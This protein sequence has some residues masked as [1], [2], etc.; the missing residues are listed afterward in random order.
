M[1]PYD[2]LTSA[3]PGFKSYGRGRGMARC[4]AHKDRTRSLS[5]REFD[6]G[7]VG[8]HCFAG[9]EVDAIV[10]AVGLRLEDL[11][12]ERD[13][14]PGA[15]RTADRR[16]YTARQVLDALRLELGVAWVL[17]ADI[18]AGR[19]IDAAARRRAGVARDRCVALIEELRHVG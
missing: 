19:P 13:E 10:S 7:V 9:C 4:P 11:F 1:T 14:R 3:L 2:R 15:G 12:P 6:S 5:V 18:A 16:P 17:L 8:L